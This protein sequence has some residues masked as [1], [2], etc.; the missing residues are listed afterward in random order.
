[1]IISNRGPWRLEGEHLHLSVT[2]RA[3]RQFDSLAAF[4]GTSAI[5]KQIGLNPNVDI[6]RAWLDSIIGVLLMPNN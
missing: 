2:S 3:R 6:S 4:T 1:M 5:A